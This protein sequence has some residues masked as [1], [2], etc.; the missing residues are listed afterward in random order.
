MSPCA[1]EQNWGASVE[2]DLCQYSSLIFHLDTRYIKGFTDEF[3]CLP[4]GSE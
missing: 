2:K 4:K 3:P 1:Y